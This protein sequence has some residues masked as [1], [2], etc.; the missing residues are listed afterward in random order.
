MMDSW[1]GSGMPDTAVHWQ[2]L[3]EKEEADQMLLISSLAVWPTLCCTGGRGRAALS[4]NY[5][6]RSPV[7]E[8]RVEAERTASPPTR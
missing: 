3:P 2:S 6:T 7:W 4:L 8:C 5:T 1:A